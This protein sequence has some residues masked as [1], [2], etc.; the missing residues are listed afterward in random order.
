LAFPSN[1]NT[2]YV[3]PRFYV[4]LPSP[5][6]DIKISN[7]GHV[8]VYKIFNGGTGYKLNGIA[9]QEKKNIGNNA[10]ILERRIDFPNPDDVEILTLTYTGDQ[11]SFFYNIGATGA[12][13]NMNA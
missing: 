4:S 2:S 10:V 12:F 11:S 7:P 6:L 5:S 8:S 1:I 13:V 9:Y 3:D